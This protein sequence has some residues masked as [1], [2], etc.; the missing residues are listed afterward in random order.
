M[1]L[2]LL[3]KTCLVTGAS[4]GIGRAIAQVLAEEG[5]AVVITGRNETALRELQQQQQQEGIV[6]YVVADLTQPGECQR[7]VDEAV[8]LL[9]PA[10]GWCDPHQCRECSGCVARWRRRKHVRYGLFYP[11]MSSICT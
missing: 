4:S 10:H 5:A 9:V 7:V 3:G 6:G 11:I 2:L 8:Q 1:P